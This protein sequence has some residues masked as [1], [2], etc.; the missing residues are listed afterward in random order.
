MDLYEALKAGTSAQELLD[1]FYKDLDAANERIAAEKAEEEAK[2]A[3]AAKQKEEEELQYQLS[4]ARADAADFLADYLNILFQKDE[5]IYFDPEEIED[6]LSELEELSNNMTDWLLLF[7]GEPSL[8][9]EEDQQSA[10][11]KPKEKKENP[12]IK[13]KYSTDDDDII[14]DFLKLFK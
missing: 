10:A 12:S 5:D 3:A 9:Q 11:A 7:K 8:K 2:A 14:R 13:I 1:A 4:V 6:A